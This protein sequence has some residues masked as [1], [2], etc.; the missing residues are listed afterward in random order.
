MTYRKGFAN[1]IG[2][3]DF[4]YLET[5]FNHNFK[6]GVRGRL[7]IDLSAG[8]FLNTSNLYFMDFKHFMGNESPF[9]LNNPVAGYRLLSYYNYSTADQYFSGIAHY[10]FR[11]FLVTQLPLLRM[12]GVK[13]IVFLSYLATPFTNNYF[14]LGYGIDNLFRILRVEGAASF[15]DGRYTGFGIKI[16]IAT[17]ITTEENGMSFGF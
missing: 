14:E 1:A 16:G 5:G 6:I 11:K 3:T 9:L 4:D 7:G 17:S 15:Q 8:K 13:E 12:T 10:Q 2:D